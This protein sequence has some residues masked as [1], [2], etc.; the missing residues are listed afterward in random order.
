MLLTLWWFQ[1]S[2][3][4]PGWSTSVTRLYSPEAWEVFQE[5]LWQISG[6]HWEIPEVSQRVR[7]L[8]QEI[9]PL[10][11]LF[12]LILNT[13]LHQL[14]VFFSFCSTHP[15]TTYSHTH[16]NNSNPNLMVSHKYPI[17]VMITISKIT[18]IIIIISTIPPLKCSH[19]NFLYLISS[20][21]G[22]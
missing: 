6:S 18:L 8:A 5:I 20:I 11:C 3:Q 19:D 13:T 15:F 1:I 4:V 14:A 22:L 9:K 7:I 21:T 10:I 16:N 2:P 17:E 12:L